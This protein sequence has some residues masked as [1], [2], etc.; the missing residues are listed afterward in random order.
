MNKDTNEQQEDE[1]INEFLRRYTNGA[2]HFIASSSSLKQL[3]AD[4]LELDQ[5][6]P[7]SAETYLD[8]LF[9][10]RKKHAQD[11][12]A[13]LPKKPNIPLPPVLSL[14]D[15]IIECILFGLNGAAITLSAILVEFAIK[16]AIVDRNSSAKKYDE[17]EWS[18]VEKK[19]LGPIIGE[20]EKLGLFNETGIAQLVKFKNTI[21]NPWLHYNIKE[22]NKDVVMTEAFAYNN[23]T[24]KMEKRY[25]LKAVENPFLW[26]LGKERVDEDTVFDAFEFADS[27]VRALFVAKK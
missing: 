4:G 11:V 22:I 27:V 10:E 23:I 17:K 12:L 19:E 9:D 3:I 13:I 8:K 1:D 24:K 15:E 25:N 20:A 7:E 6:V 16:H 2:T 26:Q 14:Y 5:K 21:R 18:R